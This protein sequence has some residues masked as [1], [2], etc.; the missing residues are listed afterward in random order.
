MVFLY[1]NERCLI[2][3]LKKLSFFLLLNFCDFFLQLDEMHKTTFK[4]IQLG[5]RERQEALL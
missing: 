3:F 4:N 2:L 1:I 5:K